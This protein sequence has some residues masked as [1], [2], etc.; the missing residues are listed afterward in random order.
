[1]F[2][3]HRNPHDETVPHDAGHPAASAPAE[4]A[5]A[6]LPETN[7]PPPPAPNA[8]QR[9]QA[10]FD[11]YRRRSEKDLACAG[12]TAL[13]Q[14]LERFLPT[15]DDLERVV[16]EGEREDDDATVLEG[17]RLV[18]ENMRKA[19]AEAGVEEIDAGAGT[20]FDP[21]IHEA[22]TTVAAGEH[23]PG[24]VAERLQRGF[25][26][27]ETLIRPA[28]VVVA[29][30]EEEPA[31]AGAPPGAD[32]PEETA[33]PDRPTEDATAQSPVCSEAPATEPRE[34]EERPRPPFVETPGPME[35]SPPRRFAGP[36]SPLG[37]RGRRRPR[38]PW[39][40]LPW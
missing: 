28:R 23:A 22:M 5:P 29:M 21:E 40:G 16:E 15:L 27:G 36:P 2:F 6:S 9:L 26:L 35:T 24:T 12:E 19:L 37:G 38:R 8:L 30:G 32:E 4:E 10:D 18:R 39:P 20:P 7:G 1:M 14:F 25:R 31:A 34:A 13:A 3:Q 33:A 17:A 11:R